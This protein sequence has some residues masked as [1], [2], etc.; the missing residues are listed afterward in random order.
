MLSSKRK[1]LL[2]N[3]ALKTIERFPIKESIGINDIK[4]FTSSVDR[5]L[6]RLEDGAFLYMLNFL[7]QQNYLRFVGYEEDSNSKNPK[8]L[9]EIIITPKR[10]EELI[11]YA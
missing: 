9:Y 6:Y 2:E 8:P 1:R 3:I 7:H 10:L 5:L 11:I 4:N